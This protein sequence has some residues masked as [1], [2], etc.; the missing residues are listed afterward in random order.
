M[1]ALMKEAT[2]DST[3]LTY[4]K[5]DMPRTKANA[6]STSTRPRP[7]HGMPVDL[8]DSQPRIVFL[9]SSFLSSLLQEMINLHPLLGRTQNLQSQLTKVMKAPG[10]RLH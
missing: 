1:R 5:S 6:R 7:D 3:V 10:T 4:D 8:V 2:V 9:K